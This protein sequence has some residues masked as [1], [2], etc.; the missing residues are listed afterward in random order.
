VKSYTYED[1]FFNNEDRLAF[2]SAK[3]IVPYILKHIKL[4]S[5]LDV[6]CGTGSWLSVFQKHGINLVCGLDSHRKYKY[7]R[8]SR[9]AFRFQNF[10]KMIE[11]P[12][13]YDLT[14]SLEVAEHISPSQSQRFVDDLCKISNIVIFSAA[15]PGQGGENHINENDLEYWRNLFRINGYYTYDLLRKQFDSNFNIAPWYRFNTLIYANKE[16]T[17][18]MSNTLLKEFISENDALK[19]YESFFWKLRKIIIR[20]FPHIFVTLISKLNTKFFNFIRYLKII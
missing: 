13:K 1:G 19:S 2:K 7:L 16:G 11:I 18:N 10:E 3:I 8:I 12:E 20:F 14:I 4:K 17:E 9:N 15:T 5:V 6:G